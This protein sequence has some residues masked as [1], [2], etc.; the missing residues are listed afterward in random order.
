MRFK[1]DNK[2][3]SILKLNP[4]RRFGFDKVI[5]IFEYKYFLDIKNDCPEQFRA[6]GFVDGK[7]ITLIYEVR[8]DKL[9]EYYHLVTYW[10]ATK[11]EKALYEEGKN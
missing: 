4:K 9:G 7:L 11:T 8:E 5:K 10:P 3:E 1:W 2:K 6:I